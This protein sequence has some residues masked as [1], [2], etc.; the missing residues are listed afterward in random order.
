MDAHLYS[1]VLV[2]GGAGFVGSHLIRE[3]LRRNPGCSVVNYDLLTYAGDLRNLENLPDSGRYA[4]VQGDICDAGKL[5]EAIR[6]HRIEAIVN[7]AAET[8]VDR[9]IALRTPFIRANVSGVQTLLDVALAEGVERLLQVS[10]DEVYGVPGEGVSFDEEAPLAP[11]N[12][13]A[14]SKAAGDL[15]CR[16]FHKTYGFPVVTARSV[17]NYGPCQYPEKLIPRMILGA[18]RNEKLPLYGDG[19][20][21]RSWLYVEEHAGALAAILERGRAGEA[22]NVGTSE[23]RSNLD[24]LGTLLAMLGKPKS[25]ISHVEDRLGHDRRYSISFAKIKTELG[26]SPSVALD[27]GLKRT[28]EWY[29]VNAH[30]WAGAADF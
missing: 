2:T 1:R 17:N 28:V 10:T 23:E 8:H 16:A 6:R 13:Y 25:L 21:F 30:R 15:L 14:A 4:F 24:L 11:N 7:C 3:L 9:S 5:T 29:R 22:Y 18:L 26:W 12:P 27:E 19:L 20:Y